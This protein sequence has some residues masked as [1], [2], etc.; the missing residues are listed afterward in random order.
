MLDQEWLLLGERSIEDWG[1]YS[2][3][4]SVWKSRTQQPLTCLNEPLS[5]TLQYSNQKCFQWV[6]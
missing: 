3:Y 4:S 2:P 5:P 6:L 1:K